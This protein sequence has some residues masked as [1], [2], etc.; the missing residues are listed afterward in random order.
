MESFYTEN[1]LKDIGLKKYGKD[2]LISRYARI[3][4]PDKIE[5]GNK[6]RIDDFCILSGKIKIGNFVHISA[7]VALYGKSGIE[8]HDY[9]GISAKSVLYSEI[10]DFSNSFL[11]GPWHKD[12]ERT[13]IKGKIILESYTQIGCGSIIFPGVTIKE[14]SCIGALSLIKENIPC[15]SIY[16]GIPAKLIKKRSNDVKEDILKDNSMIFNTLSTPPTSFFH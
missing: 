9:S 2:V 3:F 8:I 5:I 1:E 7:Y 4:N 6:V 14:G 11:I 12:E 13:L 16:A 15:W 10:D